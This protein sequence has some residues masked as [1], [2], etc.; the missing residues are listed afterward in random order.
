MQGKGS[1]ITSTRHSRKFVHSTRHQNQHHQHKKQHQRENHKGVSPPSFLS[2]IRA[3]F[4]RSFTELS[5]RLARMNSIPISEK[6]LFRSCQSFENCGRAHLAL[7]FPSST[8]PRPFDL[9]LS[10]KS[11]LYW[12]SNRMSGKSNVVLPVS[13]AI[14]RQTASIAPSLS[15]NRPVC[16]SSSPIIAV[17]PWAVAAAFFCFSMSGVGFTSSAHISL[18]LSPSQSVSGMSWSP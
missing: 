18:T 7:V 10:Q 16:V 17:P 12:C 9:H 4:S 14:S 6:Q 8:C 5:N 15:T 11:L 1:N 2:P 13:C 3:I